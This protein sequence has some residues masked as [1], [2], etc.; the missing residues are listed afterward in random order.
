MSFLLINTYDSCMVKHVQTANHVVR[1]KFVFIKNALECHKD[2]QIKLTSY[3]I[4]KTNRST[5]N[6]DNVQYR[7]K[8]YY[9]VRDFGGRGN[10]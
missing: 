6:S 3:N 10:R 8:I 9:F 1:T 5:K 2:T 7:N 4:T